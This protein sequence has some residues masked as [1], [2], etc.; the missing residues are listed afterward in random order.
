[1]NNN[2]KIILGM[3]AASV[4]GVAVGMLMAPRRG[5]EVRGS[6]RQGI[7]DLGEKITDFVQ[8]KTDRIKGAA[9]EFKQDVD[10][11]KN[12]AQTAGEHVKKVIS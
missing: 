3:I 2:T 9:D 8:S 6:I 4:A 7:D 1:M 5:S 12:D 11:L 10:I